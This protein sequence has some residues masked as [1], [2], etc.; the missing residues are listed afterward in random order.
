MKTFV[1]ADLHGRFDLL[2]KAIRKI[3]R[4][5]AKRLIFLG[6]YADRG[7]QSREVIETLIRLSSDEC[8]VCLKGNH[9]DIMLQACSNS[10]K[11]GWW[12]INGGSATLLSYGHPRVGKVDL[13]VVPQSHLIW[14]K[15]LPLYHMDNHRIYVHAGVDPNSSAPLAERSEEELTWMIYKD[16]EHRGVGGFHVV[17]GHH[18]HEDG[19]LLLE[20]RTNLD[21]GAFYTDRLV[22]GVFDDDK[23]GGPVDLI[24][25]TQ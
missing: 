22:I 16:G 18:Q 19:P 3:K 11:W 5:Q 7:P 24:E 4:K 6:D 10:G 21:T 25:V 2:E 20:G 8:V 1:I 12:N 13:S 9:E 17:H 23:A 15:S 14:V